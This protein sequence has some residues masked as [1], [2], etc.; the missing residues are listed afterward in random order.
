MRIPFTKM[1]GLG[2]DFMVIDMISNPVLL[3]RE[4]V[5]Q[6]ADRHFGVGFDQLLLVEPPASPEV[7]FQYRIFNADGTEVEHCG[8]GARCF[9]VFVHDKGLTGKNPVRVG[10]LNGELVLTLTG[11]NQVT[12]NM[13]VPRLRP[14]DIPFH[15]PQQ[16]PL[17]KRNIGTGNLKHEVEF[18][19]LSLGNPHAVLKVDDVAAAEVGEIGR[20]LGSHP[21]FTEGVN[22]GF[23]QVVDRG[24]IRLR[25]YERGSGETLAC[26]TGACAAVVAGCLEGLL[27]DT[28]RV[29]LNGG[30]LIVNWAGGDEPVMMSGPASTV[31]EGSIQ[32]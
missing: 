24:R 1:Q 17:Y 16:A 13:G 10:T 21:H 27:D 6:L 9:A 29:T 19:A 15:A 32:V 11:N 23:M 7:D 25:V 5:R 22:V 4:Q 18:A 28:V 2:N 20:E 8:N 30:D 26:G 31:F 12:V 14:A 3:T